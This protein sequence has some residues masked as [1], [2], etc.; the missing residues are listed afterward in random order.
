MVGASRSLECSFRRGSII[1]FI[2]ALVDLG[3]GVL[4]VAVGLLIASIGPLLTL[5][6]SLVFQLGKQVISKIVEI[7]TKGKLA[8]LIGGVLAFIAWWYTAPVWLVALIGFVVFKA[9]NFY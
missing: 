4:Q 3:V 6:G 2:N 8:L 1:D 5:L 9:V 7:G